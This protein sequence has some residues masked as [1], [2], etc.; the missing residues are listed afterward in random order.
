MSKKTKI[1]II[2]AGPSGIAAACKL[3]EKGINDLVILEANNRIGGR[4]CTLN[5]GK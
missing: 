5:F 1:I 3:L 2:G 4:I